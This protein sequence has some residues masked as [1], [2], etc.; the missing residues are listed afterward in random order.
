MRRISK[1]RKLQGVIR[2]HGGAWVLGN[3]QY[4]PCANK[5]PLL[6]GGGLHGFG[7]FYMNKFFQGYR[8]CNTDGFVWVIT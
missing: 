8:A 6:V 4:C 1:Q 7:D 3:T 5:S 2:K